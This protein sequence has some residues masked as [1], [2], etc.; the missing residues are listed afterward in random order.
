MKK[1]TISLLL[2][3]MLLLSPGAT[4]GADSTGVCFSAVDDTLLDLSQAAIWYSGQACV[5]SSVF[6]YLGIYYNY[7]A[8]NNVIQLYSGN[9]QLFFD[10][11]NGGSY[12]GNDSKFTASATYLGGTVYVPASF[13]S[14]YFGYYTSY[15]SGSGYGDIIR[16]KTGGDQLTDAQFMDAASSLMKNRLGMSESSA[17]P[18][19]PTPTVSPTPSPTEEPSDGEAVL[20]FVGLPGADALDSMESM[21][22]YKCCFLITAAEAE[23][24]PDSVRR[25]FCG[26]HSIGV[27][28]SS[29]TGENADAAVRAIYSAAFSRPAFIASDSA[30][31]TYCRAYAA[32]HGMAYVSAD[33]T[34]DGDV[35]PM[36]IASAL[37][38]SGRMLV[39]ITQAGKVED[40]IPSI[41]YY[42]GG[43]GFSLLAL[44]ETYIH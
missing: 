42:L 28:C 44:R 32:E 29:E 24:S 4:A 18:T 36:M 23:T 15:I 17:P 9:K 30:S 25:L 6:S 20:C 33:V 10:L 5:P 31:E 39:L 22:G 2:V 27:Y 19:T 38:G 11:T 3:L 8:D 14:G 34:Y 13:V 41:M 43:K 37:A 16:I 35:S 40:S 12:S 7:F 26:G 21:G 1:R